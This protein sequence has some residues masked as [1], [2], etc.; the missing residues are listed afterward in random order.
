MSTT[1]DI[2]ALAV[3]LDD[4]EL[5]PERMTRYR[6]LDLTYLPTS[7]APA[8]RSIA[9]VLQSKSRTRV[10]LMSQLDGETLANSHIVYIGYLSGLGMLGDP[11]LD[12]SRLQLGGTYDELID[13]KTR[14]AYVARQAATTGES[15]T[16]CGYLAALRGPNGHR[17]LIVAGTRDLGS[18]KRRVRSV[19]LPISPR[20][21]ARLP[22]LRR[23]KR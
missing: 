10:L 22:T 1:H 14:R 23:S 5:D 19:R 11:V 12:A 4:L 8:L 2:A 7:I 21:S 17:M 20:S 16:D 15:T 9:S 18:S 6:D 13:R 3:S